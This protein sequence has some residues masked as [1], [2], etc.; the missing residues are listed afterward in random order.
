MWKELVRRRG[1]IWDCFPATHI[2]CWTLRTRLRT[3]GFLVWLE[4]ST[5]CWSKSAIHGNSS[6]WTHYSVS[7]SF[8]W[9]FRN[10]G[11]KEWEGAWSDGSKEW[12]PALRKALKHEDKN[13]GVFWMEMTDF[14]REFNRFRWVSP[15]FFF[16]SNSNRLCSVVR[17]YS[18][19]FSIFDHKWH[20]RHFVGEWDEFNAGGCMVRDSFSWLCFLQILIFFSS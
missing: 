20:T 1:H 6:N 12:T 19:R 14:F 5:Q 17:M 2:Q 9:L 16:F 7:K 13:D 3:R 10:R 18:H 11:E 15:L 8:I 4:T